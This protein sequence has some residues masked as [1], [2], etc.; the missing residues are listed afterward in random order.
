MTEHK[1][2][3][4]RLIEGGN[5]RINPIVHRPG[6]KNAPST[7][8]K[9]CRGGTARGEACSLEKLSDDKCQACR[10][11]WSPLRYRTYGIQGES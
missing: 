6:S 8:V 10:W 5:E 9:T 4:S 3:G 1:S 2:E 7:V 11:N